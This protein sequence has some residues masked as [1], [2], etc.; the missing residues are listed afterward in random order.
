MISPWDPGTDRVTKANRRGSATFPI[1]QSHN[2]GYRQV[3]GTK[4]GEKSHMKSER[5]D[6]TE[7]VGELRPGGVEGGK[8]GVGIMNR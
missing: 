7:E 2:T 3:K 8:R 5:L 4:R 1:R 6:S